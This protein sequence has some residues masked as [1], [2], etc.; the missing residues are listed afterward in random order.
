MA[1]LPGNG[2]K[3]RIARYCGKRQRNQFGGPQPGT[4]EHFE[5]RQHPHRERGIAPGLF[6]RGREQR[7]DLGMRQDL[8]Q[9]AARGRARQRMRRI[10]L[11][12]PFIDEETEKLPQG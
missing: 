8:R 4:V 3:R 5:Q 11:A 9:R 12:Q 7:F 10:I 6:F 1:A 2:E